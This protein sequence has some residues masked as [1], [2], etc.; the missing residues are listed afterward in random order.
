MQRQEQVNDD[1][2]SR[3]S[4]GGPLRVQDVDYEMAPGPL[5]QQEGR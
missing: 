2:N 5:F 4:Q 3:G 1:A